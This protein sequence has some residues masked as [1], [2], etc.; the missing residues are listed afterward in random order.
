MVGSLI[1]KR[2][3]SF[4]AVNAKLTYTFIRKGKGIELLLLLLAACLEGIGYRQDQRLGR[5][6]F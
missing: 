5:R 1:G 6:Q 4:C 3:L 2:R